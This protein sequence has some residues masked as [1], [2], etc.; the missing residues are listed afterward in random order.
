MSRRIARAALKVKETIKQQ[1]AGQAPPTIGDFEEISIN[2]QRSDYSDYYRRSWTEG[3]V[4]GVI[5]AGT[6]RAPDDGAEASR[7]RLGK[8]LSCRG[9]L[10]ERSSN[11][12]RGRPCSCREAVATETGCRRVRARPATTSGELVPASVLGSDDAPPGW[13]ARYCLDRA[14]QTG[15]S[16]IRGQFLF[17]RAARSLEYMSFT[18]PGRRLR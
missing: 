11:C 12:Q 1:A 15:H 6:P 17:R 16:G 18:R 7:S 8:L 5:P 2:P 13:R 14:G 9:R 10:L 3:R 4:V